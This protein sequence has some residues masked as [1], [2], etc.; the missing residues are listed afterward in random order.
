M[1]LLLLTNAFDVGAIFKT[2]VTRWYYYLFLG[3]FL[4][5]LVL[6]FLFKKLPA[7]NKLSKTQRLSYAGVLTALC[8]LANVFDIKISDALQLSFVATIGFL[9]GY[10]LGG[11]Y[12]FAVCF[13]GD[14]I[15]AIINPH[16]A[17]NPIIGVGTGLWGLIFGLI[18]TFPHGKE[19]VK[20]LISFAICSLLISGLINTLGIFLMYGLGKK[21]FAYYLASYPF[22][23]IAAAVNYAVSAALLAVLPRLLP[24]NKFFSGT[25]KE[26]VSARP[27]AHD[28]LEEDKKED[29]NETAK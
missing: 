21:T 22:K 25:N 19:Q 1:S 18:F 17:Y 13:L 3:V 24:K 28:A 6:F 7:R 12:G 11:A 27:S 23:L 15:G 10:L 9:A 29:D 4:V 5:A 16:G 2:V 26:N 20:L 14:L 8:V